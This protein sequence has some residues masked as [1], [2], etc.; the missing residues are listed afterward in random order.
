MPHEAVLS[1]SQTRLFGAIYAELLAS[2]SPHRIPLPKPLVLSPLCRI[3]PSTKP[4]TEAQPRRN[5]SLLKSLRSHHLLCR[6]RLATFFNVLP[7]SF[8]EDH[9]STV[10][11]PSQIR[12]PPH[13]RSTSSVSIKSNQARHTAFY[14]LLLRSL[15]LSLSLTLSSSCHRQPLSSFLVIFASPLFHSFFSH[16]EVLFLLPMSLSTRCFSCFPLGALDSPS[17]LT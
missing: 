13:C 4:A 15:P 8:P 9:R 6:T 17:R 7:P 1:Y 12:P 5:T 2:K 16:P 10:A 11:P 14:A 3:S